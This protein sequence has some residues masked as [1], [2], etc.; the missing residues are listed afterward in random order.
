MKAAV[1]FPILTSFVLTTCVSPLNAIPQETGEL[2][3]LESHFSPFPHPDRFAGHVYGDSLYSF[4]K[5]YND[6]SVAV[7]IP[8]GFKEG[9]NLDL[10]FY[11]H[12]WGNNI[13]T[14]LARFALREQI[15]ASKRNVILVFPEGPRNAPDS[16]GGRLEEPGVFK[17]LVADVLQQL[18]T[19]GKIRS[20][21]AGRILLSG[22]SGA[23]RVIAQILNR[24]GLTD[25]IS[26]VYL[27]DALYAMETK[28]T[29]W[30]DHYDGRFINITTPDGGTWDNTEGM[31]ID[32]SDWGIPH[33]R[34]EGNDV[35]V[36]QL[37]QERITLIYSTLDHSEVINP[38]LR[39]F[40]ESGQ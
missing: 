11:F 16:F 7:F 40:L 27:F 35:T 19:M 33:T 20:T 12:G 14:S 3:R 15:A 34:I 9:A 25:H 31:E 36:A 10:L 29:H 5:H 30:L 18:Q 2:I 22:H 1:L 4:Q 32:L 37:R 39:I 21:Q 8:P 17:D 13:D 24:G 26:E 23:Y 38:Y 6:S 28:Y